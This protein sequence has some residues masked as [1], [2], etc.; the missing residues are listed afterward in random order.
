MKVKTYILLL[1]FF[2]FFS[3]QFFDKKVPNKEELLQEELKKINWE[4][5]DEFPTVNNCDSLLDKEAQK[6]C[7]FDYLIQNIQ[8][9]IGLDTLQI[10]YPEV[11]TI[12]LMVT[13]NPDASIV[14]TTEKPTDTITYD[15][16]VIDSILQSKLVNFPQVEPAVKRG[17]KVKSQFVLPVI[18]KVEE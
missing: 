7:F 3:C 8:E 9:R 6:H 15:I 12:N 4:E 17:V 2:A 16:K 13:I 14:F 10:L 18:L 11:D 1:L 5:V